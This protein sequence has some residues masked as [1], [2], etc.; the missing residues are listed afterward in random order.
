MK[1]DWLLVFFLIAIANGAHGQATAQSSV[2][3]ELREC[4]MDPNLVNR[5]NLPPTTMPVLIDIIRKIENNPNINLDLRMLS[6]QLLHTFRQDGIEFHQRGTN[7]PSSSIVLPFAPTFHSFHRHRLLLR[8]VPSNQQVLPNNTLPS[9]LKCALHNMISTTVDA[10]VRGD[11][12]T[13][14]SLAQYRALRTVR[15]PRSR[16]SIDDDVE[17]IDLKQLGEHRNGHMM[18]NDPDSDVEY[19]GSVSDRQLLGASA[20]PILTGAVNTHWG[21][22]S[23]G[24]LI[25]GIAAGTETQQV[26]ILELTKGSV[27][28]YQNVQSTITTVFPATLSGDL[29][30]A[31]LVQGTAGRT[32]ITVGNAGNWNSSAA[33]RFYMLSGRTNV[34]MTDPEIRG[35]LDGFFLGT[36]LTETLR[37]F[38]S[39]KLSQLLDMYYNPMNGVFN[40][41]LRACNRRELSQQLIVVS[42]LIGETRAF[43]AA[44]DTVMPLAGTL[45]GGIEGLVDSA[46][47]NLQ[48]YINSNLNDLNCAISETA[49]VVTRLRTNIYVVIDA[50]WQYQTIYPAISHIVE[51]LEVGHFGS[52]ITILSAFDGSVL[53]NQTFSPADFHVEY[54][55]QRHLTFPTGVNLQTTFANVRAM[56]QDQLRN[57]TTLNYVG[58]N[59]T[60]LLFL[61]NAGNIENNA[62]VAQEARLT[63]DYVPDLRV[64]FAT[65]AAQTEN[66]SN[67]VREPLT[68]ITTVSLAAGGTNVGT[69]LGATLVGIQNVGRRIINP[70]CGSAF[71]AG[72]SGTRQL[73]QYVDPGYVNYYRISPNYFFGN[74]DNTRVRVSRT[75]GG[76]GNLVIC[77]SRS[78]SAPRQNQTLASLETNAVTCQ[79]LG[80]T[81]NVEI[82]LAGACG[83]FSTILSCP[84][85]FFS[86]EATALT[87]NPPAT[88]TDAVQCRFPYDVAYQIQVED[89][90]CFSSGTIA[91]ASIMIL[92]LGIVT[93]IF[94]NF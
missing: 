4:Y 32:S 56:M 47:S 51:S 30:E 18:Q 49:R 93:N 37:T 62:N 65:S 94:R 5:N 70:L 54:T 14:G 39:L 85:L 44:L 29:A 25:A 92:V 50:S 35:A 91:A 19:A 75:G 13:C 15:S 53:I 83:G 59:A 17:I 68:D 74:N 84:P 89:L 77:H 22:V 34:E 82:N 3:P 16:R 36:S 58:G 72:S 2:A 26:P 78:V 11:E 79:N 64:L 33:T 69:A 48:T 27:L 20:C 57:E 43:T 76:E 23:A 52:S 42:N 31:V 7:A 10:R 73:T 80:A 55:Q 40:S 9:S 38:S 87:T 67:L 28:N 61:L 60:V 90:Q 63:A 46:V 41:N 8:I 6:T 66:L 12:N 21:A 71:S 81:G 24:N 86:V 45:T 1:M 88:C